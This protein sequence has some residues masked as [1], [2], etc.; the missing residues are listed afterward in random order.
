MKDIEDF[1]LQPLFSIEF[2]CKLIVHDNVSYLFNKTCRKCF[3]PEKL[4]DKI[5][6]NYISQY[7]D[8]ILV[9]FRKQQ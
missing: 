9:Q 1:S 2:K 4:D 7:I 6:K 3:L 5:L 8:N